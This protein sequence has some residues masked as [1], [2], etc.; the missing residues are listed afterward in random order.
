MHPDLA[1]TF[2]GIYPPAVV[3]NVLKTKREDTRREC[4]LKKIAK[5]KTCTINKVPVMSNTA[6]VGGE[7]DT[8]IKT[9]HQRSISTEMEA[10]QGTINLIEAVCKLQ[11]RSLNS[12][13]EH[14]RL[15]FVL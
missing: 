2:L 15:T 1:I 10:I 11:M 6:Q 8:A 9:E 4:L 5:E 7:P 3:R 14:K 13:I 12:L